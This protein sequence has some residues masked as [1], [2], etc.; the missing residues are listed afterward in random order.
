MLADDDETVLAGQVALGVNRRIRLRDQVLLFLGGVDVDDLLGDGTVLDDP[1]RRL[2]EAELGDRRVRGE[3]ANQTNVR[4]F[5]CLDRAHA[6]VMGRVNVAHFD[7]CAFA[8]QTTST[9]RRQAAA[10]REAGQRVR[11]VHELRQLRRA[12]ELLQRGHDGT[13]VDDRLRRDRVDVFCRHALLDDALHAVQAD[14][15]RLLDQLAHGA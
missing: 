8:G 12:E 9:K 1:V 5:W 14:A 6:A 3:R 11:L 13:N 7:R 15:E 2:N 10:M 4:S